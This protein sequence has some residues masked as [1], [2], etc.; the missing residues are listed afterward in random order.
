MLP[1]RVL[2]RQSRG[3][4]CCRTPRELLQADPLRYNNLR[5]LMTFMPF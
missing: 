4:P 1:L 5:H 2:A 3:R